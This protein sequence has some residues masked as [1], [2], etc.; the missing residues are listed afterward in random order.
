MFLSF[1]VI[2][3]ALVK[4]FLCAA[5][6]GDVAVV[7]KMINAGVPV[8]SRS[9]GYTALQ[10][11]AMSNRTDVVQVLLQKGADV[12]KQIDGGWTPLHYAAHWNSTNVI[13]V[14]MQQGASTNIKD[15]YGTTPLDIARELNK[16]EV[17]RLLK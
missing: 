17:V 13:R 16:E 2:D 14:L 12:N 10:L 11:A 4:R 1:I 3:Q 8:H 9:E 7:V 15:K 5:L 6:S